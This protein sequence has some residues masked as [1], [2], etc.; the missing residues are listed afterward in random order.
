MSIDGHAETHLF[1]RKLLQ[2]FVWELDNIMVSP[3][4]EGG[5]KE[6]RDADNNITISDYT[7]K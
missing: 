3:S 5:L 4:E 1:P 7:M 6:A 2:V